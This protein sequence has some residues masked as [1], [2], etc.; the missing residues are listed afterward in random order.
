LANLDLPPAAEAYLADLPP[1]VGDPGALLKRP[2]G[3]AIYRAAKDQARRVDLARFRRL[4]SACHLSY[5]TRKAA[6]RARTR[7]ITAAPTPVRL[8]G[9]EV[10]V[11]GD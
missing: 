8:P 4:V 5:E 10:R 3:A 7:V 11:M 1:T 6:I 2:D 9:K